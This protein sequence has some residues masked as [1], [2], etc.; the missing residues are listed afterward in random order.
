[1][2]EKEVSLDDCR[3]RKTNA[4]DLVEEGVEGPCR[5]GS[6][7]AVSRK[8]MKGVKDGMVDVMYFDPL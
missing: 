6:K 1:M 5:N 7:T 3:K 8:C 2:Y 4:S